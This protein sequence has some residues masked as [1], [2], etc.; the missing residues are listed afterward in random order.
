MS[1]NVLTEL[2]LLWERTD[3]INEEEEIEKLIC[4]IQNQ[5]QKEYQLTKQLNR[6]MQRFESFK[7]NQNDFDNLLSLLKISNNLEL[8][9]SQEIDLDDININD[10]I[11]EIKSRV[12]S[13]EL[14]K[15]LFD[16]SEKTLNVIWLSLNKKEIEKPNIDFDGSL[17]DWEYIKEQ[18]PFLYI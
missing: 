10:I 11:E 3:S 8:Q 6:E 14:G 7:D 2:L 4:A 18:Y 12:K 5:K 9:L 16:E 15:Y 17:I 13:K 1:L